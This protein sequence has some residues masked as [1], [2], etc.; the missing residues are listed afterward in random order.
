MQPSPLVAIGRLIFRDN[1]R[2]FR[3]A[4]KQPQA[5]GLP[6]D[7]ARQ[8]HG[9]KINTFA[10]LLSEEEA[11][12]ALK[13][14]EGDFLRMQ[15]MSCLSSHE[16]GR[17]EENSQWWLQWFLSQGLN[18]TGQSHTHKQ[19]ECEISFLLSGTGTILKTIEELH[20][21]FECR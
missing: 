15:C 2:C 18:P 14:K 20:W 13:G 3:S 9:D 12:M 5:T 16:D 6:Q 17:Q 21:G 11:G 1:K 4:R 19:I 7:I 8:R 10:A